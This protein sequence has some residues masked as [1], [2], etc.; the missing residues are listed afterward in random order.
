M[1]REGEPLQKT[2]GPPG[3]G[4][5]MGPTTPPRKKYLVMETAIMYPN[6]QGPMGISSQAT[7]L[8]S[9]TAPSESP[10]REAMSSRRSF[11]GPKTVI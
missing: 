11:L 7:E 2:T 10:P 3:W 1:L 8:G 5:G 6:P 9:M 4:L